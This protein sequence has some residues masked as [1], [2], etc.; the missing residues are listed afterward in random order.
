M[1]SRVVITSII[2]FTL[3]PV[4][5]SISAQWSSITAE[6]LLAWM[7]ASEPPLVLDVRGRSKYR[8]GTLAGAFDAGIDPLGY[9]PDDSKDPVVMIIPVGADSVFIDAWFKRLTNAGHKVWIL[10]KGL[11]GWVEASGQIETPEVTY[12]RPG[13]VPFIIPRGLCEGNEP[14]QIFE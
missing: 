12:T 8:A 14:A 4:A 9:L 10:K 13:S 6:S 3:F 11:S 5:R 7:D 1:R 2:F